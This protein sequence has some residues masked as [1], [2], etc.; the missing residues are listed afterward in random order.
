MAVNYNDARF[1]EVNRQKDQALNE[2][3]SMY[4]NMINSTDKFYNDQINASN[5]YAETQKELQ[6]QKTDF[7]IEQ[8]NQN[9]EWAKQDY[10]KEQKGAYADYMKASNANAEIMATQGLSGTGFAESSVVSMYNA[11]QNRVATARDSFNRAIVEYDNQ[12]KEA[13]LQNS[14]A[15]AEIA[16]QA[17]QTKLE[18]SLQG[19]QYKNTLLQAQLEMKNQT[20]DR[21]YARWQDVLQ[22]INTENALAE[23]RRQFNESLA[24]EKEQ[25]KA[26]SV[27]IEKDGSGGGSEPYS[28]AGIVY[29]VLRKD[30]RYA[31]DRWDPTWSDEQ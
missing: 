13:Q 5:E 14:S 9:K 16:Y 28:K 7:A 1:Q 2:V 15:L 20:E 22:Q 18:L 31:A 3:N 10:T 17:L 26:N 29:I 23:Q 8:V 24:W 4:N 21:Y 11:Y 30:V 6:Q 27:S 19:F 12:I 25:A